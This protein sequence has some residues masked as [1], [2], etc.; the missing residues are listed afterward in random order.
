MIRF[1]LRSSA[2]ICGC[3]A[4]CLNASAAVTATDAWVRGTVPA[5]KITGA[6]LTLESSEDAKVVGVTSPA[7]KIA[8]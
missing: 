3:L 1:C 5:Q 7:A 4:F 8:S 2:F 6:F